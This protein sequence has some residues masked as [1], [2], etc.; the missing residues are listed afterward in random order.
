M[1]LYILGKNTDDKGTQLEQLTE[2]LL[3]YQ[4]LENIQLNVISAGGNEVDVTAYHKVTIGLKQQTVKV[5]VEC[6]ALQTD[7]DMTDWLKFKGK[8]MQE[9]RKN[10]HTI[11]IMVCLSG[12]KGSVI[13]DYNEN[14]QNDEQLQ[15]IANADLRGWLSSSF[16][17]PPEK[18]IRDKLTGISFSEID[19][20]NL[21]YYHKK[22]YWAVSFLDGKYTLSHSDGTPVEKK[23]VD[24]IFEFIGTYSPYSKDA[25]VDI[26]DIEKVQSYLLSINIVLLTA[27]ANGYEGDVNEIA[28]HIIDKSTSEGISLEIL[29]MA[30]RNNPFVELRND[31][32]DIFLKNRNAIDIVEFYKAVIYNGCPVELLTSDYYQNN[33]NETLLSRI[34]E[35]QF[36]LEIPEGKKDDVLFLLKYSPSAM[37][38]ALTPDNMLHGYNFTKNQEN[39]RALFEMTFMRKLINGFVANFQRQ[40][41]SAMYLNAFDISMIKV[42]SDIIITHHNEERCFY[43]HSK[44]VLAKLEG[45]E[46]NVLLLESVLD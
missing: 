40:Q 28:K 5:I 18:V 36:G 31:S 10:P 25:F 2:R 30:I 32:K 4:G 11:G 33:I 1:Q 3:S 23:E 43:T 20:I 6:K 24:Y 46:D 42:K 19:T 17:L 35:I 44:L 15:L 27:L 9:Q 39:M 45:N 7:I 34:S 21:L 14:H 41:L 37:L 38:Y 16:D 8:Y 12:A 22:I 13:G 29:K 26:R